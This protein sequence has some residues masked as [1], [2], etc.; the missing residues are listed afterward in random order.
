[1]EI[2][3]RRRGP[4]VFSTVSRQ[5]ALTGF[6]PVIQRWWQT[7]FAD[8]TAASGHAPPT[9]A[10]QDGW[11]SIRGGQH[12]LIAAP[13]GSGK[14]LAAFLHSIDALFR[15]GL[16]RGGLP[17]ETRVIYVSPLKALSSDIHLNLAEPRREIRRIAE[18][19]GLPDVH[20]TAAV[21]SGDTPQSERAAMLRRPP[22]ILVTTPE[23]LYL[24]LTA[25]RSRAMLATA[26]TV[27]VDEIHA[28]IESRR[29]AHL[30][31]SLERLDA[32]AGRKLQRIGLSATQRPIEDVAKFLVG[33]ENG[34]PRACTIVD[35]GHVRALDVALELP[36]SALEAVMSAEVWE[37]VYDRIAELA[38]E[39]RTTLVFVNTRRLAERAARHLSERLGEGLVTA[40]HGSLAKEVRLDAETRLKNGALRVLVATASLELG[41]DIGHVDLVV[42]LG[43]PHR[44]AAFL[45]RVGRSGHFV[46]GT[47]KGRLFPLSR[48]DLIECAALVR[49]VRRGELDRVRI[50]EQPTDV[51]AQ[52]I[53]AEVASRE[54]C[55]V[56]ALFALVRRAWPYRALERT[57]F[58]ETIA[59]LGRGYSTQ[60]GRKGALLHHDAVNETLRARKGS[61]LL[62]ITSGGAIPEVSDFRVLLEP[63]GVTVGTVNEDFAVESLPGDIFQLG[64]TSW[65]ILQVTPGTVRVA[66]AQ[67]QPPTIPFWLG[68]APA[69]T[70]ELSAAVSELRADVAPMLPSAESDAHVAGGIVLT[71]EEMAPA[72]AWLEQELQLPAAAAQQIAAYLGETKKLLGA[73]PTQT[74]L[75]L[76]RFFDNAGGMQLVLHAPFGSRVNRAWGLALRKKFCQSYNFELQA[77]ATEEGVLLSLGPTHSF[78]LVDVFRYLNP[79]TVRETLIQAMLDSPIFETRWRWNATLSLAVRR[80]RGGRKVP[81]QIQRMEAEDLLTAVFPDATAC[82]ENIAGEREVP[83]DPLVDQAI[84]D[85]LEEAMDLPRLHDV[86]DA[87]FAGT[88]TLVARDTPEPSPLAAQLVNAQVY[89]FL[90]DAPLEERRTLAVQTRRAL[91]PSSARE[92]GT[93]DAEAIERVRQEAWPQAR[94]RDE[95][96]DALVSAGV[97]REDE[98]ADP[99]W[100]SLFER[101]IADGRA[102]RCMHDGVGYWVAIDR[103]LEARALWPGVEQTPVLAVPAALQKEWDHES[104]VR[105]IVR[106]RTEVSG[107]VTVQSLARALGLGAGAIEVALLALEAEGRVLRG[108]FTPGGGLL[109]WC[110]R[111]L[112]ARIHRYTLNRLRAEIQ[113]VTLPDFFRFLFR[114]QALDPDH[115]ARGVEG[116]MRVIEQLDGCEAAAGA[117]EHDIL[118]ARVADYESQWL[119]TLCM[120]GRVAWGRRTADGAPTRGARPLRTTPLALFR[121]EQTRLWLAPRTDD[122]DALSGAAREVHDALTR[123]GASFFHELVDEAR[124]L[125]TQVERALGEL[126]AGG[127]ITSDSFAGL[128]ALLVP[129]SKRGRR[130]QRRSSAYSIE[131]AGRWALLRAQRSGKTTSA[132]ED[133]ART[134]AIARALLQRYGVV[135]RRLLTREQ[136]LP[137]WRELVLVYRRLEARGEIRGGRFVSGPNGEQFAL[138]DAVATLRA[139]R[140]DDRRDVFVS[141]G[142][143]DPLNL[144]GIITPDE[145]RIASSPRTRILFHDGLPIA[146]LEKGEVRRLRESELPDE[147]LRRHLLRRSSA[148]VIPFRWRGEGK[149]KGKGKGKQKQKLK[150]AFNRRGTAEDAEGAE[151]VP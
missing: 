6:H 55:A 83:S 63:E 16:E 38:G 72:V 69:R 102:A 27:I 18:E 96:Y 71:D 128:R 48:D 132:L 68:E 39:H 111:R 115:R 67:G 86:L 124:L 148:I 142:A 26:T 47:P 42:Q 76:E 11:E 100:G 23:S 59:M 58:E 79:A 34:E 3:A 149:G 56:D 13:T 119:D 49:S 80:N 10:Q 54:E 150:T 135:F 45:Q 21:R 50:P 73:V 17:A 108:Q 19:L 126:A 105:E 14:T 106:S 101:L 12:T 140:R 46:G 109:E 120:S 92:L 127:W 107:P 64:N 25:E 144:I 82:F 145:Q 88:I 7:R 85:C 51:L 60:R 116:V 36:S 104:A 33:V 70:D 53:V 40:H 114:W 75:V 61:R 89:Q 99:A 141:I 43:S 139:V 4:R 84:R 97:I 143:A 133:S 146:L 137:T 90:D 117:W 8:A 37:E 103:I 93:L 112:L 98:V 123:S 5:P 94:D 134:E 32:L 77:V 138:P 44:I 2:G 22:H 31:L 35:R 87:I 95:L 24:L 136:G 131:S 9:P 113:P 29:G 66:D 151:A 130:A 110:D 15:E 122:A 81:A 118:A 20:V 91:Q 147:D 1:M 125:P 74:T 41:I 52:Q 28:V 121:R 57:Q 62:A 78:P 30:A 65:R 129:E